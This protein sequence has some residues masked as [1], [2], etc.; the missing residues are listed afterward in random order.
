LRY[1]V[2][3][4]YAI[5]DDLR[6]I[7]HH[8]TMRLF[9]RALSRA[10]LPVKYSQGFNPRPRMSLPLPRPVGVASEA[11][12]LVIELETPLE[13]AIGLEQLRLQMPAGLQLLE[14]ETLTEGQTLYPER[15][16]YT[17][18]LPAEVQD[19]VRL[20]LAALLSADEVW[21][22]REVARGREQKVNIREYL[23]DAWVAEDGLHWVAKVSNR[24]TL[25]PGELVTAL[26][27]DADEWRHRIRRT[28]VQ[29]TD[30][31]VGGSEESPETNAG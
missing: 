3:I 29:W 6:F 16:E 23:Q 1:K 21:A 12:V 14:A 7:S 30:R 8:D 19:R 4:R 11:E 17:L 13:P 22:R 9:E 24:G 25:R 20:S 2:A 10:Q 26:E 31:P 5:V 15:V 27:L 28:R 18:P